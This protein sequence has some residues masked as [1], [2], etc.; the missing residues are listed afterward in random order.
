MIHKS[1][2]NNGCN[3][4]DQTSLRR[5]F[6]GFV[7]MSLSNS[8][9]QNDRDAIYER[10][11][12]HKPEEGPDELWNDAQGWFSKLKRTYDL[13]DRYMR[14]DYLKPWW[15]TYSEFNLFIDHNFPSDNIRHTL[16]DWI[17]NDSDGEP[18]GDEFRSQLAKHVVYIT[19]DPKLEKEL[20]QPLGQS[21]FFV[22]E[23][24]AK[25]F[26]PRTL[27]QLEVAQKTNEITGDPGSAKYHLGDYY[28]KEL[29][30][31]IPQRDYYSVYAKNSFYVFSR[32]LEHD[33][34]YS[35]E[36]ERRHYQLI[37]RIF[38]FVATE[39]VKRGALS[40]QSKFG[41]DI[42]LEKR[43]KNEKKSQE[44]LCSRF[45]DNCM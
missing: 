27:E 13:I 21:D 26:D 15:K 6:A 35:A 33:G 10:L 23:R 37:E 22:I 12:N 34:E 32:R 43:H 1:L 44:E 36:Q 9:S 41:K 30:Q 5:S 24:S 45:I 29:P 8:V 14:R 4:D 17:C 2:R 40:F 11:M 39:L 16:C 3:C 19:N 7:D 18:E 20:C 31:I 25:F 42:P 38:V 28:I